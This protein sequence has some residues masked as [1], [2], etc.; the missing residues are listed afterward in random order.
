MSLRFAAAVAAAVLLPACVFVPVTRYQSDPACAVRVRTMELAP[1]QIATLHGCNNNACATLLA[2]AG[3][4]AAASAVVSGS[5]VVVGNV[6][7]WLERQ[8]QCRAGGPPPTSSGPAAPSPAPAP[9]PVP[10][11]PATPGA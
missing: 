6:V 4:T 1:V 11:V 7:Y 10:G 9:F 2:A 3:V 5:I 8:A